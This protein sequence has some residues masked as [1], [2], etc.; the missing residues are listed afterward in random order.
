MKGLRIPGVILLAILSMAFTS[1]HLLAAAT[2]RQQPTATADEPH[3]EAPSSASAAPAAPREA[4]ASRDNL[5]LQDVALPTYGTIPTSGKYYYANAQAQTCVITIMNQQFGLT[6]AVYPPITSLLKH[7]SVIYTG[8]EGDEFLFSEYT[9]AAG[10][11]RTGPMSFDYQVRAQTGQVMVRLAKDWS[12]LTVLTTGIV[13]DIPLTEFDYKRIEANKGELFRRLSESM[14]GSGMSGSSSGSTIDTDTD[15]QYPGNKHGYYTCPNC[16]G[17]GRCP[18][19]SGDGV[20][21]NPY[22]GGEAMWCSPCNGSGKC[23]SCNGS[24]KK[25]GVVN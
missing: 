18:H 13:Y 6:I 1:E 17:S 19:C 10:P 24:G 7:A 12:R 5:N 9:I 25:Y 8:Q 16:H 23:A 20:A 11:V 22:L 14:G 15:G 2:P 4:T 3:A 21:G